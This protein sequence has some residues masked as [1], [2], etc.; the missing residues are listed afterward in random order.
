M[1]LPTFTIVVP[2]AANLQGVPFL[3]VQLQTGITQRLKM[4]NAICKWCKTALG[5]TILLMK[6]HLCI[7]ILKVTTTILVK[8][9]SISKQI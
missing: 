5:R 2:V 3:F 9:D 7:L 6:F 8:S 4:I 1:L